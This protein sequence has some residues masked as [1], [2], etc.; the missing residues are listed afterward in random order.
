MPSA[1]DEY[2]TSPV[3]AKCVRR[4]AQRAVV[5]DPFCG[6]P[7]QGNF[8]A[9]ES[10]ARAITICIH[11]ERGKPRISSGAFGIDW[12]DLLVDHYQ[13]SRR[14]YNRR[15]CSPSVLH[16]SLLDPLNLGLVFCNPP[17]SNPAQK[18]ALH[19]LADYAIERGLWV[20][21]LVPSSTGTEAFQYAFSRASQVCWLRGR[22]RF[23]EPT[24]SSP[25]SLKRRGVE[26]IRAGRGVLKR[27]KGP[28]RFD[29][30]ILHFCRDSRSRLRLF[31]EIFEPFGIVQRLDRANA[32]PVLLTSIT[33]TTVPAAGLERSSQRN[34]LGKSR[35]SLHAPLL[36]DRQTAATTVRGQHV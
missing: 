1:N 22:Q 5:L 14:R 6:S 12:H 18:L 23:W 3:L 28:A 30:A 7:D 11:R 2:R 21:A 25:R 16:P 8:I 24:R 27:S 15:S 29:S 32:G 17:Y 36:M 31:A 35:A 34:P 33:S 10:P 9:E 4:L 13:T 19:L 26:A 20:M